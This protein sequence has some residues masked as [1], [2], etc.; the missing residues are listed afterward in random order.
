MTLEVACDE[1]GSEGEN[2]AGA[3][4]RVFAHASTTLSMQEATELV[5][6]VRRS[7]GV[8]TDEVKST[9]LL[10]P[11]NREVLT[12]LFAPAGALDG[13]C[14]VMLADKEFFLVAKII[15]LLVEESA[16]ERGEDMYWN[17][18]AVRLARSLHQDGQRALGV[19]HWNE[20]LQAFNSLVRT[21]QRKGSKTT[22]EEFFEVVDRCRTRSHRRKVDDALNLINNA[23]PFAERFRER[24]GDDTTAP[25]LD[26]IVPGVVEAARHWYHLHRQH[27]VIHHD[28][29][30]IFT[31][32]LIDQLIHSS[33]YPMHEFSLL[34]GGPVRLDAIH[35][36]DSRDD[37]R[38]Q[39]ADWVAG[40]ARSQAAAVLSS[41]AAPHSGL[42]CLILPASPWSD[43]VSWEAMTGSPPPP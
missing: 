38:I 40:F 2:L 15:D 22:V 30:S 4:S 23:R 9:T 27:V 29:Q 43:A 11:R 41:G 8:T 34:T 21:M 35:L 10:A 37:P 5:D 33:N 12:D 17:R 32:Q 16:H 19:D 25:D 26:P 3:A 14:A 31:E 20:L 13:R 28:H 18:K 6:H 24:L 36:V 39:V 7:C 1:S 42:R